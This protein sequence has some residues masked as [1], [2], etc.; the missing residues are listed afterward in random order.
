MNESWKK[1]LKEMRNPVALASASLALLVIGSLMPIPV[2]A[3]DLASHFMAHYMFCAVILIMA[4]P[5][6]KTPKFYTILLCLVLA[7]AAL[8]V[9]P[10]LPFGAHGK[11]VK[12]LKVL[13]ANVLFKNNDTE[14]FKRLLL[15]QAPDIAVVSEVT[16]VFAKMFQSLKKEYPHQDVH[17]KADG[18]RGLAVL[19]KLP[20]KKPKLVNLIDPRVP[21]QEFTVS[22]A[23]QDVTFLSLHPTTPINGMERRDREF[24]LIAEKYADDKKPRNFVLIGD[25]NATP[26]CHAFKSLQNGLNMRNARIGQGINATWPAQLPGFLRIPIDHML[27]TRTVNVHSYKVLPSIKSDHLP[28]MAELS[29]QEMPE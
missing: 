22:F 20:L 12:P 16:P 18:A 7:T 17:P 29:L 28:M 21:S 23:K 13:Q 6:L 5:Y 19:S 15:E 24:Q 2:Q 9:V 25:F 3:I 11:V 14:T 26:W 10:F 4:A 1:R 8:Q 27:T